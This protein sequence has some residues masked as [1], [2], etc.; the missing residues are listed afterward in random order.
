MGFSVR[1]AQDIPFTWYTRRFPVQWTRARNYIRRG[2]SISSQFFSI[3]LRVKAF[4]HLYTIWNSKA[5]HRP[6]RSPDMAIVKTILFSLLSASTLIN[7]SFALP[8]PKPVLTQPRA[9]CT[10]PIL[11]KEWSAATAEEKTSYIDAVNCLVTKPSRI[12][13]VNSTLFDD[14]P[15]V[16]N[17][18]NLRSKLSRV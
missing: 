14:F 3:L 13:L 7:G 1:A 4:H 11:R 16:H 2:N 8:D 10:S 17:A 15:Y 6:T 5:S 18:L 9:A 12:G